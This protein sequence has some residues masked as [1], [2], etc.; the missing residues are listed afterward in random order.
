MDPAHAR[1]LWVGSRR[2][3]RAT[4]AGR[5]WQAGSLGFDGPASPAIENP[6]VAPGQVWAGTK[7][8]GIFRSL[9]G[10]ETWSG[11]LSGPEIPARVIT[12]IESHPRKAS[13]MVVTIGG[14]GTLSRAMPRAR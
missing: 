7:R 9:D 10:G 1:T 11:D 3:W 13:R 12:R 6:P 2:L 5:D 8:G 4:R 14:T